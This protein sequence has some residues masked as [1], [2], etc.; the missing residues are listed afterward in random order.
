MLSLPGSKTEY[1]VTDPK[2]VTS[3]RK[4]NKKQKDKLEAEGCVLKPHAEMLVDAYTASMEALWKQEPKRRYDTAQGGKPFARV[5]SGTP[6]GRGSLHTH[7]EQYVLTP[8]GLVPKS[9][10]PRTELNST[11]ESREPLGKRFKWPHT[12][13]K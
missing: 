8:Y 4:L 3:L 13:L 11:Y 1:K 7:F 2:G 6:T 12:A 9:R 5:T 10:F